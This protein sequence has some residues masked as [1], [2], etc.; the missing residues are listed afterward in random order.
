MLSKRKKKKRR[1]LGLAVIKRAND[2][3]KGRK[4]KLK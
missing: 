1:E 2:S 3:D 4:E